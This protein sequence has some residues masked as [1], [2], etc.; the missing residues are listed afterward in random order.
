MVPTATIT[1]HGQVL[2]YAAPMWLVHLTSGQTVGARLKPGIF[3]PTPG[4]KVTVLVDRYNPSE[5]ATITGL[6]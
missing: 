1:V 2:R 6:T 5:T 3:P 4:A